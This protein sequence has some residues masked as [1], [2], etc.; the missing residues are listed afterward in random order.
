MIFIDAGATLIDLYSTLANGFL[1]GG[2]KV[3]IAY[4]ATIFSTGK[5][6]PVKLW[7]NESNS[8]S[9]DFRC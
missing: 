4:N 3:S 6:D 8:T 2:A 1:K 5:F 9:S 7:Q